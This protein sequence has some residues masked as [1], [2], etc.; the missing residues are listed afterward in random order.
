MAD[1]SG[2]HRILSANWKAFKAMHKKCEWHSTVASV[3]GPIE[4]SHRSQK[5]EFDDNSDQ[6]SPLWAER[7]THLFSDRHVVKARVMNGRGQDFLA[8]AV[9]LPS[10]LVLLLPLTL[11]KLL[12]FLV[13]L[14]LLVLLLRI[15][16][17]CLFLLFSCLSSQ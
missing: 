17:F 6:Q 13:F 9:G 4:S 2:S 1:S 8:M 16:L 10:I 12:T 15:A 14:L 3:A 11:L 5:E 7:Q